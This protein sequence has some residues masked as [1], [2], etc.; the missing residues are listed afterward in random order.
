MADEEG[1]RLPSV[2]LTDASGIAVSVEPKDWWWLRSKH[3]TIRYR[4]ADDQRRSFEAT[5]RRDVALSLMP[6]VDAGASTMSGAG[7]PTS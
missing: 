2:R 3:R 6:T 1:T 5:T 7:C 4:S